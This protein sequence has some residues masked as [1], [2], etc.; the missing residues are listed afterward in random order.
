MPKFEEVPA[1][2]SE[3][4]YLNANVYIALLLYMYMY[5]NMKN[6]GGRILHVY[7]CRNFGV[8]RGVGL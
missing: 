7:P 8:K 2:Q 1:F 6:C 3:V 4:I 5:T